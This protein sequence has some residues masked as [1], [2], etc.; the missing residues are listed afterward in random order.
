MAAFFAHNGVEALEK[1]QEHPDLDMV[2]TDINMPE[3][4]GLN[5]LSR[6]NQIDTR[7]KTVVIS[8]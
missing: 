6:L 1:L 3:M 5:L 4:D 2:V 7:L 8:A